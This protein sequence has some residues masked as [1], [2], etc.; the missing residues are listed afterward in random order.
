MSKFRKMSDVQ[1]HQNK[2]GYQGWHDL[3]AG[4]KAELD[5]RA[6]WRAFITHGIVAWLALIVS[7]VA[8]YVSIVL[9]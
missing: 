8:L 4:A 2:D 6:F 9:K 1:L 3:S 7:I 5:R